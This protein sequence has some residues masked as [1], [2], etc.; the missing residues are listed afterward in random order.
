MVV[1]GSLPEGKSPGWG[2]AHLHPLTHL[3]QA[4]RIGEVHGNVG[5]RQ[6]NNEPCGHVQQAYLW[7]DQQGTR[8]VSE[9]PGHSHQSG[10]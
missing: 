3:G 6:V 5:L 7:A 8:W 10:I 4:E 9:R 2:A 1:Q